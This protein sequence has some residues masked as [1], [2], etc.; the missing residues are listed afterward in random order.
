MH[1]T[2]APIPYKFYGM[3]LEAFIGKHAEEILQVW[4]EFAKNI[5]RNAS[6]FSAKELRDDAGEILSEVATKMC[7]SH[8][9]TKK[10]NA[11]LRRP[12][13][14]SI[15]SAAE[16]HASKRLIAGFTID[17]MVSEYRAL[18]SSVLYLWGKQGDRGTQHDA[19]DV[20]RFNEVIDEAIAESIARYSE[21]LS[22]SRDI[23]LGILG[24]DL[25]SPIGSIAMSADLLLDAEDLQPKYTKVA[26]RIYTSAK[27]ANK[28]IEDLLDFTRTH[29][30]EG[31]PVKK[32][33]T[34][35]CRVCDK[36]VDEMRGYYPDH[37]INFTRSGDTTG[38]FDAARMGQVASNLIGNAVEHGIGTRPITVNLLGDD[39]KVILSVN[40]ASEPIPE[41][42]L[43]TMFDPLTRH[44]TFARL[45]QGARSGMGLGLYIAKEIVTAHKGT[46]RCNYDASV[47][48]TFI[49]ELPRK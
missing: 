17:Q 23:F 2:E 16:A 45:E 7:T 43:K 46:I 9:S 8:P 39:D 35:L 41:D 33:E 25:R 11:Q 22:R 49:V 3:R 12:R 15:D 10:V 47:G 42:D 13:R 29:I 44:S 4:E 19:E 30:G 28:I 24:H 6:S 26:A 36:I 48:T 1:Y 14:K 34:E 32:A 5:P 37:V 18:R 40:N 20:L 31:I 27:R 21:S 38:C